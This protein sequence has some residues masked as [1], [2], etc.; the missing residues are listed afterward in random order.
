MRPLPSQHDK[1][2]ERISS[3]RMTTNVP[4]GPVDSTLGE[5]LEELRGVGQG[6]KPKKRRKN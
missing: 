6:E 3:R 5:M 2:V 1:S 4:P